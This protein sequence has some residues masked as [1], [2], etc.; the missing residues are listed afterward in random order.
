MQRRSKP[1]TPSG[2]ALSKERLEEL[3]SEA[4]VD[5]YGDSEQTLGL[6]TMIEEHLELP[7][8]A[9]VLGMEVVVK[10]IDLTPDDQIVAICTRGKSHQRIPILEV[11]VPKPRPAGWDWVDAY[12]WWTGER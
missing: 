6:Y 2:S 1:Q 9:E 12:R 4:T 11:T 3:I 10:A 8:K 5:A 7:F